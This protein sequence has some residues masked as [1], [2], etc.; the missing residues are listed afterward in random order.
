VSRLEDSP[1]GQLGRLEGGKLPMRSP[2]ARFHWKLLIPAQHE[3][4]FRIY[5][6]IQFNLESLSR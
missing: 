2:I 6:Y 4:T 5:L 3:R 1:Q